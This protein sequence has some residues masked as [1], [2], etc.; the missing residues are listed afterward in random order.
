MGFWNYFVGEAYCLYDACKDKKIKV[1]TVD[2][3]REFPKDAKKTK[4]IKW[5]ITKNPSYTNSKPFCKSPGRMTWKKLSKCIGDKHPKH[6]PF[7]GYVLADKEEFIA[8]VKAIENS[9]R[10]QKTR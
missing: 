10:R 7:F 6:C 4:R 2:A 8:A 9:L 1:C 3:L 5:Q